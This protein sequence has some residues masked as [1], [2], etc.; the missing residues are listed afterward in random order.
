MN[1]QA[2]FITLLSGLSFFIGYLI[3]KLIKDEKKNISY[4]SDKG[5]Y[6]KLNYE[7]IGNKDN[8]TLV[9][10]NLIT[11]RS[12]QIRV[13]FS[14]RD[15]PLYGDMKYNKRAKLNEQLALFAKELEFIHP[16]TKEVMTFKNLPNWDIVKNEEDIL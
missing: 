10:I 12:H 16:V 11:G 13:Q 15:Y 2:I 14:S 6:S 9:K 1:I 7:V 5:K 8:K 4:V 3:T